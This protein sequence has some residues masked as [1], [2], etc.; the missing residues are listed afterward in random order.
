MLST[1]INNLNNFIFLIILTAMAF[2]DQAEKIFGTLQK[3]LKRLEIEL[4][5][6]YDI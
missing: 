6:N 5:Y 4:E 3:A 2:Q 1:L